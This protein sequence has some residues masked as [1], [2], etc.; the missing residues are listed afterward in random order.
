[1]KFPKFEIGQNVLLNSVD[2]DGCGLEFTV[3]GYGSITEL[4]KDLPPVERPD[5]SKIKCGW[6]ENGIFIEKVFPDRALKVVS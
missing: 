4:S 3:I 2:D 1:V 5:H 6:V